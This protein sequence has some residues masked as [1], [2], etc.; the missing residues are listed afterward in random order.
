MTALRWRATSHAG[1]DVESIPGSEMYGA[2]PFMRSTDNAELYG[3][4]C[5][6][7]QPTSENDNDKASIDSRF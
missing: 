4:N 2:S 5:M 1:S 7:V 3:S 6:T